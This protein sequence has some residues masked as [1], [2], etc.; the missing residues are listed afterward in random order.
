ML[1]RT[2]L[3]LA[4]VAVGTSSSHSGS[5][6]RGCCHHCGCAQVRKVCC[7]V[8]DK[9]TE[10]SFEYSCVCEDF[11]VPGPSKIVGHCC[12]PDC[13]GCCHCKPIRQ[14]TCAAVHTRTKLIKTP[15]TKEVCT[16]KWVVK[17]VCCGC[18]KECGVGCCDP[19][20][21]AP[22]CADTAA[23]LQPPIPDEQTAGSVQPAALFEAIEAAQIPLPNDAAAPEAAPRKDA[24]TAGRLLGLFK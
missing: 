18:G 15:V 6:G 23:V 21:A 3:A 11:C 16:V 24:A 1:R 5:A 13:Q 12:Q 14:P 10:T 17:T 19:S 20:C 2:F 7:P 9:K 8:P 4:L 22:A